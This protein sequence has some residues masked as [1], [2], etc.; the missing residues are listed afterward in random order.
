MARKTDRSA[1]IDD[2]RPT[3]AQVELVRIVA[4]RH[5]VSLPFGFESDGPWTRK[6]LDVFAF[7]PEYEEDVHRRIRNIVQYVRE[8]REIPEI[9]RKLNIRP[10]Q[11]EFMV[12]VLS[13]SG[14]PMEE[15]VEDFDG[16]P[17]DAAWREMEREYEALP[18]EYY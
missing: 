18:A 1:K 6:F 11:A 15:V 7:D 3:A 2:G 10:E 14:Y 16:D 5:E 12:G 9:A 4:D 17:E 13:Q 8:G